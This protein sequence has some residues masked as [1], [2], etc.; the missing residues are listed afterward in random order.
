MQTQAILDMIPLCR[1]WDYHVLLDDHVE[2]P[3]A[4]WW[5]QSRISGAF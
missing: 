3:S 4:N 2:L 5:C 1:A